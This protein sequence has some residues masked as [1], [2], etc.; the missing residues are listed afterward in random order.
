[1]TSGCLRTCGF[2]LITVVFLS[3]ACT[4]KEVVGTPAIDFSL[5]DINGGRMAYS[6]IKGKPT[7]LYFFASW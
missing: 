4:V 1:M 7:I 2:I 5:D 6:E 3:S